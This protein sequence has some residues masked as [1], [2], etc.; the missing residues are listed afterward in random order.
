MSIIIENEI[1]NRKITRL[2][3]FTRSSKALHILSSESGV[4]AVDF[5]EKDIY[6]ANDELRMDGRTDCVNCSVQYPN[7]WYFK[8]VKDKFPLFTE[9]VI[10]FVNPGLLLLDTTEFCVTN[11]A[12]KKGAL[13]SKGYEAFR[14]IFSNQVFGKYP[15]YRTDAMLTC[16]PTDDQ[17]EVLIYKNI[18]RQDIIGVAV[19]NEDQARRE[20]LRWYGL[21][22]NIPEIPIIIAPH[23]FTNICSEKIRN[24]ISPLE[25]I[26]NGDE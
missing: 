18:S 10:L 2:C 3:H 15:R 21:L 6:D 16:C 20:R 4:L 9:W 23:L 19:P 7:Y 8:N 13:I 22:K 17:A 1:R 25:Y 26:F 14:A 5:I 11:A 24:G 12:Y